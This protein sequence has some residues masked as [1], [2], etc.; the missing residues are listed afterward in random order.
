MRAPSPVHKLRLVQALQ[1]SGAIVAMTGDG[2]NDA[3]ALKRADVGVAMGVKGT[4]AAKEAAEMV[5]ADDNFASIAHA[6]EEGRA[7]YD[8]IK[9]AILYILPTNGGEGGI[10]LIAMLLGLQMPI[11]PVQILWVNMVTEVTLS[12]SLAFLPPLGQVMQRP[13]RDPAEPLI[14]TLLVWRILMVT[15]LMVATGLSCYFLE[16][17]AGAS[18]ARARTASVNMIV[19]GEIA[20][21]LNSR[22]L[23]Q[24][25]C[26]IEGVFGN[27]SA[28]I[29]IAIVVPLQLAFTYVPVMQRMFGTEALGADTWL[30]ILAGGALIFF[31][32]EA[33]KALIR[34]MA[35][36]EKN[37]AK[38]MQ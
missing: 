27:R 3:P 25:V 37:H 6:V 2:V 34:S 16:V 38:Q 33:E 18:I 31:C 29:G 21:L 19:M 24:S 35:G 7:V 26:S 14:S 17:E 12:L 4:E 20:Y 30:R 8:N 22:S 23:Y 5:L 15:G 1:A 10:I 11:T 9:K 36:G 13:P 28:W 32:A